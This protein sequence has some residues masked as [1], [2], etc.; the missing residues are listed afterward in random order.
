MIEIRPATIEDIPRL[1]TISAEAVVELN[2]CP[3]ELFDVN[4]VIL[5]YNLAVES[6]EQ[7]VLLAFDGVDVVGFLFGVSYLQWYSSERVACELA[8]YIS[9]KYRGRHLLKRLLNEY[10]KWAKY[11]A[12]ATKVTLGVSVETDRQRTETMF[13]LL[14]LKKGNQVF[15]L[16]GEI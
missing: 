8:L 7:E 15:E 2:Y 4:K 9:P 10:Y 1:V 6:N 5:T 13:E 14:G 11:T 12:H 16:N 3:P